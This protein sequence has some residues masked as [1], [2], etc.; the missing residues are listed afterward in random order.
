MRFIETDLRGAYVLELE[1]RLDERGFFA[2]VW[3]RDEFASLGLTTD[4]AQCSISR[5]TKAG[6]LRGMHFQRAPH[7]E[8]K[9]VRCIR[10]AIYDVIVD[11][12][13]DT[14][15]RGR[16]I[17]VELDAASGRALYVPEGF[18][19]GFQTLEHD[20]DVLYMI[21]SPYAP[22]AATGVRWDDPAF[23]IV[24]PEAPDRTISERDRSWPDFGTT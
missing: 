16:W 17:G 19:H 2:R 24:W 21:S 11:L 7:E 15:T 9:V 18:A 4:I 23:G 22:S 20:T 12:R 13:P 14:S 10:G 3:C 5:T 1:Q 6:T 8:A